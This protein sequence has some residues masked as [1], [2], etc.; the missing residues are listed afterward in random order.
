[1]SRVSLLPT[2]ALAL[3]LTGTGCASGDT[4]LSSP[5]DTN[6]PGRTGNDYSG[7]VGTDSGVKSDQII[8]APDF[9]GTGAPTDEGKK[10]TRIFVPIESPEMVIKIVHPSA[11]RQVTVTSRAIAL[12]GIV[13]GLWFGW[14]LLGIHW[15]LSVGTLLRV[16]AGRNISP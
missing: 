13:T 1:M 14:P 3:I 6:N 11:L 10:D 4:A 5:W 2:V 15:A 12:S 9:G 7:A 16:L 8:T